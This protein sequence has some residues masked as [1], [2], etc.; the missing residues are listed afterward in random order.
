[1]AT[2]N[3]SITDDLKQFVDEQVAAQSYTSTSEYLRDLIRRQ[4]DAQQLRQ[5]LLD[6]LNSGPAELAD[7][8]FFAELRALAA[9]N[10]T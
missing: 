8:A 5:M 3:I 7:A 6:G 4:R 9:G 2:M 1:M 10:A